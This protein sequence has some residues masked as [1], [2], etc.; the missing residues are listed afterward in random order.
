M[1]TSRAYAQQSPDEKK[2]IVDEHL[3][4]VRHEVARFKARLPQHVSA[5]DLTSAGVLGLIDAVDKFDQTKGV[6]FRNYAA[7]RVRG[8]ILDELRSQDWLS[9]PMRQ[10]I[11]A[12][13]DVYTELENRL[14]RQ[15]EDEEVAKELQMS[16][17]DFYEMLGRTQGVSLISLE[18]LQALRAASDDDRDILETLMDPTVNDP[19]AELHM[20]EVRDL[21][22]EAIENLP[23]Q[24]RMVLTLYYYEDLNMK[25]VGEVLG[26]T[27]SRVSQ[28]RTAALFKLRG[29]LKSYFERGEYQK[30]APPKEGRERKKVPVA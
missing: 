18:E 19:L 17:E 8:A 9:R 7:L 3:P 10:D 14:G 5:D 6:P 24:E 21:L 2:K 25:E 12:L 11:R 4:L 28:I 23:K 15:P 22:G 1:T 13:E 30:P 27:E 26:V 16:L 20:T 29:R